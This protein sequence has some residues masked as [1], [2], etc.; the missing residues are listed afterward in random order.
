M[1]KETDYFDLNILIDRITNVL[2]NELINIIFII[3]LYL[4]LT[5]LLNRVYR[6][7]K[8]KLPT[9]YEVS[10][11][12][13]GRK[14]MITL[15]RLINAFINI[16]LICILLLVI[17]SELGLDIVPLITGVGII[18]IAVGFGSQELIRDV[19]SGLFIILE[20]KIRVGDVVE[21]NGTRGLVEKI[22]I[23]T[24]SLRDRSGIVHIFQNGK[25]D[26]ISNLTKEWSAMVFNIGVAYKEN[27]DHVM[28]VIQKVGDLLK[29]D[30][31]FSRLM[32][33]TV[34]IQ[35]VNDFGDSA[36]MIGARIKTSP[37]NQW[38]IGREFRKR[39]KVAFD[40]EG[41]EIPFPHRTIYWGEKINPL[42]M[43]TESSDKN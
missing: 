14:R 41:I 8:S 6:I 28:E 3:I 17:F 23:R 35:G 4:L 15:A 12:V 5:W 30:E 19:I 22:E 24:V 38:I 31:K 20:N 18:G 11:D 16:G 29:E 25:I 39:L 34:E 43:K 42:I 27:I 40:Q 2:M 36:I 9:K 33:S 7:I 13:E 37:G 21:I 10:G 32:I 26:S 1:N